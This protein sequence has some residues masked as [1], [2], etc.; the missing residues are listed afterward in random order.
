[1][2]R[3]LVRGA[4]RRALSPVRRRLE[5]QPRAHQVGRG[6]LEAG[7]PAVGPRVHVQVPVA[8][9]VGVVRGGGA[10]AVGQA[11]LPFGGGGGRTPGRR[12][13]RRGPKWERS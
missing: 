7:Q 8:E 2:Q 13:V 6:G 10:G 3:E 4:P 12:Q 1:M 11:G 5:P 9:V